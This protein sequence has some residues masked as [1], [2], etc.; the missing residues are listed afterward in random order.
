[1]TALVQA[2]HVD[3]SPEVVRAEEMHAVET[4][5]CLGQQAA[6]ETAIR[7]LLRGWFGA[8][9]ADEASESFQDAPHATER[10]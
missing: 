9:A 8:A 7:F 3:E 5:H 4:I 6:T 2:L 1:M 10:V